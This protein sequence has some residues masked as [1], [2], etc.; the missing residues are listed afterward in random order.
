MLFEYDKSAAM[1]N[2]QVEILKNLAE[3][4]AEMRKEWDEKNSAYNHYLGQ[5][6]K[7]Q[8][9]LNSPHVYEKKM[10]QLRNKI[11]RLEAEIWVKVC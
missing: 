4:E 5:Y 2:S 11:K 7:C 6:R 10:Q 1:F 9:R 3:K 8:A